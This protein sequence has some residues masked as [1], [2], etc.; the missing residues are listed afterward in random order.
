MSTMTNRPSA[1][2]QWRRPI[3]YSASMAEPKRFP[4]P[5]ILRDSRGY[6][7][8]VGIVGKRQRILAVRR[9]SR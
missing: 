1:R 7:L 4:R 3:A 2:P 5:M 9:C 8:G 6:A